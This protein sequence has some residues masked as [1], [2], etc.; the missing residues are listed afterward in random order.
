M[1]ALYQIYQTHK[2]D[3]R[4]PRIRRRMTVNK[5]DRNDANDR[6]ESRAQLMPTNWASWVHRSNYL[7]TIQTNPFQIEIVKTVIRDHLYI[8]KE[9]VEEVRILI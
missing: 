9:M 1:I 7:H 2:N 5:P 3:T 4:A 6:G 8:E